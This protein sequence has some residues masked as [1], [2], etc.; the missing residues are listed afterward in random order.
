MIDIPE[1][2]VLEVIDLSGWC[3]CLCLCMCVCEYLSVCLPVYF[4]LLYNAFGSVSTFS[5][6]KCQQHQLKPRWNCNCCVWWASTDFGF[7]D[8]WQRSQLL[9]LTFCINHQ[10]FSIVLFYRLSICRRLHMKHIDIYDL[11]SMSTVLFEFYDRY[12]LY[13]IKQWHVN[14]VKRILK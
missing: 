7:R 11:N 6:R 2:I 5:H 8:T 1:L 9:I 10:P 14:Y 3:M 12:I 13:F 4:D